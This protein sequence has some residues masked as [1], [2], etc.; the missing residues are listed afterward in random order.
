MTMNIDR[1]V[2]AHVRLYHHLIKGD[3][4]GTRAHNDFYDEYLAVMD[5]PAEYYLQPVKSVF[6]DHDLPLGRLTSR[7]DLVDPAAIPNTALPTVAGARTDKRHAGNNS[8][9][10]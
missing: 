9:R 3:G 7:G 6:Q 1:H 10:T 8:A 2:G 4:D 5:L